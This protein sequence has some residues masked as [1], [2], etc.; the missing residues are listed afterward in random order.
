MSGDRLSEQGDADPL[1]ASDE[2]ALGGQRG[3]GAGGWATSACR[4]A[5]ALKS[6]GDCFSSRVGTSMR[7]ISFVPS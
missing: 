3:V 1:E 5:S 4:D 6:D 2:L 7:L